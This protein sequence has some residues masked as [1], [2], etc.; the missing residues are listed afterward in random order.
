MDKL[1]S[2]VN[3]HETDVIELQEGQKDNLKKLDDLTARVDIDNE[4][5][6]DNTERLDKLDRDDKLMEL[7]ATETEAQVTDLVSNNI[8]NPR[9]DKLESEVTMLKDILNK[10]ETAKPH[11][12]PDSAHIKAGNDQIRNPCVS[13]NVSSGN[14]SSDKTVSSK[15]DSPE[16]DIYREARGKIGLYPISIEDIRQFLDG[17]VDD[18]DLMKKYQQSAY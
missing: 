5:L 14:I 3:K 6:V 10:K 13:P 9:L 11:D 8:A 16:K 2:K 15:Q 17:E 12:I 18:L 4:T 7:R 1:T